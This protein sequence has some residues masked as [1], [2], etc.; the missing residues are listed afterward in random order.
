MDCLGV[1]LER[2]SWQDFVNRIKENGRGKPY[3]CLIG[4]SGGVDS[5]YVAWLVKSHGL[6]TACGSPR[7]WMEF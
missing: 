4:L 5:T 2:Q 3:D 7:Q 1:K 6:A